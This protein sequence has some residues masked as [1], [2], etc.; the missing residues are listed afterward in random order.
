[1]SNKII[2]KHILFIF[3]CF[4][5]LFLVNTQVYANDTCIHKLEFVDKLEKHWWG[6]RRYVSNEQILKFSSQFDSM[7]AEFSFFGGLSFPI[8]FL[9]PLAGILI[10]GI[11][12]LSSSYCWL[13]STYMVKI[14]KGNGVIIDFS[15][16]FI[17]K[18]K[19]I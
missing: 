18:I 9:T 1:M 13:L 7:A 4:S 15:N 11:L 14:N 17:F 8:G 10:S 19:A 12:E 6:Y 16:G 2:I 5:S 3:I